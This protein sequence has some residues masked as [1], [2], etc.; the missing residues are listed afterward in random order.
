MFFTCYHLILLYRNI[1]Y[2]NSFI[3]ILIFPILGHPVDIMVTRWNLPQ[4]KAMLERIGIEFEVMIPDVQTL[5]MKEQEEVRRGSGRMDWNSY[6]TYE[7]VSIS[8]MLLLLS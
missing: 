2:F 6:H 4:M 7:E 3:N 5:V 1:T 8:K